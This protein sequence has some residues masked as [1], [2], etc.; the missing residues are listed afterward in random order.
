MTTALS[1]SFNNIYKPCD[2]CS[3][4]GCSFLPLSASDTAARFPLTNKSHNKLFIFLNICHLGTLCTGLHLELAPGRMYTA[5]E[6]IK[7]VLTCL[8]KYLSS[9]YFFLFLWTNESKHFSCVL[10]TWKPDSRE[11]FVTNQDLHWNVRLLLL[12]KHEHHPAYG[13]E[14]HLAVLLK[15]Q[16]SQLSHPA[17]NIA[18]ERYIYSH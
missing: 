3:K 9:S 6:G 8:L 12:Q 11:I 7:A 4:L 5:W 14:L 1:P 13:A 17:K 16:R 10:A 18:R 2:S 15:Q